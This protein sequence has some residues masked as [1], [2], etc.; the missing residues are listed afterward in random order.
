MKRIE[1][2]RFVLIARV[3]AVL[4]SRSVFSIGAFKA[5]FCVV[6]YRAVLV[7][8]RMNDVNRTPSFFRRETH[9]QDF[10]S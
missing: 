2:V 7:K 8:W 9:K 5:L 6:T 1:A 3:P 4:L 10:G